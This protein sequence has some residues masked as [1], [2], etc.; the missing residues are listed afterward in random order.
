M[1]S[2]PGRPPRLFSLTALA[3]PFL[4]LFPDGISPGQQ[5]EA[6]DKQLEHDE[7]LLQGTWETVFGSWVT[8]VVHVVK[9]VKGNQ[10]TVRYMDY[11]TRTLLRAHR[12]SFVSSGMGK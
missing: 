3:M 10:E 2:L 11:A 8:G 12:T 4:V 6:A 7:E 1:V 5:R 9:E